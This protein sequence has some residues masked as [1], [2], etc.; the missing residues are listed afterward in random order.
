[1]TITIH[2]TNKIVQLA[3]A[4]EQTGVPARVWEGKT[5][6]GI[7]VH[8]FI[9]RIAVSNDENPAVH[10]MFQEELQETRIPSAAVQAYPNRLVL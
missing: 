7:Y 8:C 10:K 2:P 9:T 6:T 1:M 5:D 4:D 3:G